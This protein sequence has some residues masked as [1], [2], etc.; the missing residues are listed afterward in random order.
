MALSQLIT[1]G[2]TIF[3]DQGRTFSEDRDERA[4]MVE[5]ASGKL[6]KYIKAEKRK[7]T[8]AW[9]WLPLTASATSDGKEAR[10]A[11][12]TICYNGAT[13]TLAVKNSVG[14][15][16]QYTVFVSDY[17]ESIIQRDPIN[18]NIFFDIKVELLEQ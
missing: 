8:V 5:L 2:G 3:T 18:G 14:G 10:T 12:R 6:K 17:S 16:E 9:T 13:T 11:L 7:F 1:I 4:V 15:S